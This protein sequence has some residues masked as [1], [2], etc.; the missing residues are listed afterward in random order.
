M[1]ITGEHTIVDMLLS[2]SIANPCSIPCCCNTH[3]FLRCANDRQTSLLCIGPFFLRSCSRVHMLS[4][5]F[6]DP[7]RLL[8]ST[9][10]L[11][12]QAIIYF[13]EPLELFLA[14]G[15]LPLQATVQVMTS[16]DLVLEC[17]LAYQ[18]CLQL[19]SL[20]TNIALCTVT[21]CHVI[22]QE[23]GHKKTNHMAQQSELLTL[24]SLRT[25]IKFNAP[26]TKH[27]CKECKSLEDYLLIWWSKSLVHSSFG[28]SFS[29]SSSLAV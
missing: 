4:M 1:I 26:S 14:I 18:C 9:V 12:T 15:A 21:R 10:H 19:S 6:K 8:I 22:H 2:E 24:I 11:R 27:N 17:L 16:P 5:H 3:N 13:L 29:S 28:N 23:E 7:P 20:P 25:N